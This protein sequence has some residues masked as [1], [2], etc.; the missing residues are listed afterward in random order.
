MSAATLDRLVRE[1]RMLVC[2]GSGGVGKT[3]VAAAIAL[4]AARRGRR[5]VV[6]TIDPAKRLANS[7]GIGELGNDVKEVAAQKL[8][9]GGVA[10]PSGGAL[11]AMM[12]DV[13]RTFDK[14]IE[15][16]APDPATAA[17]IQKNHFYQK[18]SSQLAG[19]QEYMAMEKL[20]ELHQEGRYDLIVLDTPPTKHALDFL[21]A[22]KR[23]TDFLDGS[24]L[25]WF[26]MP[27]FKAGRFGFNIAGKIAK[28]AIEWADEMFGMAFLK[29]LNEF[30]QAFDGLYAG[31]RERAERVNEL[32]RRADLNAFLLVTSPTR[33]T[34]AEAQYFDEQ[35]RAFG[36]PVGGLVANRVHSLF[37]GAG[38]RAGALGAALASEEAAGRLLQE[39]R[40]RFAA[41]PALARA[42]EKAI[43]NFCEFETLADAD[44]AHLEPLAQAM[45]AAGLFVRRI[46]AFERDVYDV[47]GLARLDEWL[48]EAAP[49]AV[50]AAR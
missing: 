34:V 2:C 10:L 5:A 41:E 37:G 25:K 20:Y 39:V 36:M 21:R 46:P 47:A 7:L 48:L 3:T 32:M 13:K 22:P 12:L 18:I 19:S 44:R 26:V 31:F 49:A 24:V 40:A 8:A 33:E 28:K 14:L 15:R 30:F 45:A 38:S 11:F 27:Y 16:Y 9:E 43:E 1:K 17:N 23:L 4:A 35:L 50:V 6:C 42:L 29:E